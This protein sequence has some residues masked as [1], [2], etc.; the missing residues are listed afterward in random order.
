MFRD[1]IDDAVQRA[2]R[3]GTPPEANPSTGVWRV[4]ES[5]S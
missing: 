3:L 2:K 5:L 1:G 4:V